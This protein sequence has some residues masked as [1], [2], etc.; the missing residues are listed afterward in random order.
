MTESHQNRDAAALTII[1]SFFLILGTL[2]VLATWE[3]RGNTA[4]MI[5]NIASG[6]ILLA[7]GG[8]MLIAAKRI[9]NPTPPESTTPE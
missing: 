8:V 4:A 5:V 2:V 7:V 1:G 6:S 9:R 3:A